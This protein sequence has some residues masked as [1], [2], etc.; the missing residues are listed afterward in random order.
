MI[1]CKPDEQKRLMVWAATVT[2]QPGADHRLAGDVAAGG[3]SGLAQP[4]VT[5]STWPGSMPA[6]LD[7]VRDHVAAHVGA[8]RQVEGAAHG[9]ADRGAG[10]GDDDGIDHEVSFP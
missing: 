4:S 10:G 3:A 9:L 2:G 5:S 7:G 1:A 6:A 8:V